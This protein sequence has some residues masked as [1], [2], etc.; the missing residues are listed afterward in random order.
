MLIIDY[1]DEA[2]GLNKIFIDRAQDSVIHN[3]EL[4]KKLPKGEQPDRV[5]GLRQTRNFE[6]MLYAPHENNRLVRDVI[7]PSPLSEEGHPLLFPFLVVEAKSSKSSDDWH[8]IKLQTAF[9]IYTFLEVQQCLQKATGQRSKWKAEPL[10]WFLMNKGEDWVLCAACREDHAAPQAL[11][12]SPETV[13][14][15][16]LY[17]SNPYMPVMHYLMILSIYLNY[18]GDAL[19][20]KIL[21]FSFF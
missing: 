8:S 10:V 4:M 3:H 19:N 17:W 18:G 5:Y 21:R 6:D 14:L 15:F 16:Q 9:P 2:I 13:R 1:R 11:N 20:R 7:H 12:I